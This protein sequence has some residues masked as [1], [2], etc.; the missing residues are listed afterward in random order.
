LRLAVAFLQSNA[1]FLNFQREIHGYWNK[2]PASTV[3]HIFDM[4]KYKATPW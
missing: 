1:H 4:L 3:A 2:D